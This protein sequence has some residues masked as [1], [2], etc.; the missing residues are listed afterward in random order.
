MMHEHPKTFFRATL[1]RLGKFWA[2]APA[3]AVYPF[4]LRVAIAVWT[5]PLWLAL[6]IGLTKRSTWH[7]PSCSRFASSPA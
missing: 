1:A 7:H 6:G 4:I 3:D 2:I 5:A